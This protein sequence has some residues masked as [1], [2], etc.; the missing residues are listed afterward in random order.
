MPNV[1]ETLHGFLWAR[2]PHSGHQ[3]PPESDD[4]DRNSEL[5]EIYL[6]F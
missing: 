3:P 2:D 1:G 5:A 4:P 6:C